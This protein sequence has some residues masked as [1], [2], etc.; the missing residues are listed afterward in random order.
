MRG[1]GDEGMRNSERPRDAERP[2]AVPHSPVP[3]FPHSLIPSAATSVTPWQALCAPPT[4]SRVSLM[5]GLPLAAWQGSFDSIA[6]SAFMRK[7]MTGT[8]ML[9]LAAALT[10]G[11][12]SSKN[13]NT[14]DTT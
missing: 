14:R 7:V 5:G 6:E 12:C 8:G 9:A 4:S 13:D 11:A 3:S 10:V 1:W 2:E